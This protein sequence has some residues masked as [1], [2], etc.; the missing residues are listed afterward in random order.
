[1]SPE[2]RSSRVRPVR[3]RAFVGALNVESL[4]FTEIRG[5]QRR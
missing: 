5:Q 2:D 4:P 1:M 3:V